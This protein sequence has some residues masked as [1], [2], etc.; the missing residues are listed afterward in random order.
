MYQTFLDK[1]SASAKLAGLIATLQDHHAYD[2][3]GQTSEE[4]WM[5]LSAVRRMPE[6]GINSRGRGMM[7]ARPYRASVLQSGS[8]ARSQLPRS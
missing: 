3:F 6:V 5:G 8:Q 4:P 7:P 2:I 1:I